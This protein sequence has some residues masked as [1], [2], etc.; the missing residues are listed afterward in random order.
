MSNLIINFTVILG[1]Y[2]D[3]VTDIASCAIMKILYMICMFVALLFCVKCIDLES[4]D[5]LDGI[6]TVSPSTHNNHAVPPVS[7]PPGEL[8]ELYTLGSR[9]PIVYFYVDDSNE[10]RGTHYKYTLDSINSYISSAN[11]KIKKYSSILNGELMRLQNKSKNKEVEMKIKVGAGVDVVLKGEKDVVDR[12]IHSTLVENVDLDNDMLLTEAIKQVSKFVGKYEWLYLALESLQIADWTTKKVVVFGSVDPW[13]ESIVLALGAS[14][15]L[16]LEYNNLTYIHPQITTL[17]G[18]KNLSEL[19][20]DFSVYESGSN[21][22]ADGTHRHRPRPQYFQYFDI[23]ISISSFDHDGLGRYGDPLRADGDLVAMLN[24]KK[25]IKS[26]REGGTLIVSVPVGSDLIVFNLMRQY[27]HIRLPML[28]Q[29]FDVIRSIGL[30]PDKLGT[31][32]NYMN[33]HEPIFVLR[34]KK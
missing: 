6:I 1:V 18:S 30:D 22:T 20:G 10:G 23:G 11:K 14:E 8:Y 17:C 13:V 3:T 4:V 7:T 16:T 34:P 15:V 31:Y 28:L 2:S 12:R 19:Y 27:G 32:S 9:L 29:D 26:G 5:I 25:L 21:M 33:P 24:A